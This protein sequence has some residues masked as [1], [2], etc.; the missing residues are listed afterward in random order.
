M[1][2]TKKAREKPEVIQRTNVVTANGEPVAVVAEMEFVQS[3]YNEVLRY[4]RNVIDA[5]DSLTI[6]PSVDE[7]RVL[8]AAD[9]SLAVSVDAVHTESED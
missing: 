9:E 3:S 7:S 4:A 6:K 1:P 8:F 5:E 2:A